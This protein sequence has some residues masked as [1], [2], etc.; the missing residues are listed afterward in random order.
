M[1]Y[2]YTGISLLVVFILIS[3][4][5]YISINKIFYD[6][7]HLLEFDKQ[8]VLSITTINHHYLSNLMNLVSEYGREYFWTFVMAISFIFGGYQGK[9]ITL[10]IFLSLLIVIPLNISIK[11]VLERDRPSISNEEFALEKQTDKSFPSGHA[12]LVA[13]GITAFGIFLNHTKRN[14]IIF[15]VLIFEGLLVFI[16]R[17][18]LGV[19][20]PTDILGGI[21]LGTGITFLIAT[22]QGHYSKIIYTIKDKLLT[23]K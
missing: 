11:G 6:S 7:H 14:L 9:M 21:L 17:I 22:F 16:S 5:I 3:I 8:L 4:F 18:Y 10:V 2:F 20:Y 1:R 12:S 19:H 15:S 23:E 13:A